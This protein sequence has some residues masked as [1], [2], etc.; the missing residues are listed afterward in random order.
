MTSPETAPNFEPI[1]FWY[2]KLG[3]V[4]GDT[5]QMVPIGSVNGQGFTGELVDIIFVNSLPFLILISNTVNPTP[6]AIRWDAVCMFTKVQTPEV[7]AEV[8]ER[9]QREFEQETGLSPDDVERGAAEAAFVAD[10]TRELDAI[11]ET[12]RQ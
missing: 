12:A 11:T 8:L 6:I 10:A 5:V 7:E 4:N 3:V 1:S 2:E 9:I